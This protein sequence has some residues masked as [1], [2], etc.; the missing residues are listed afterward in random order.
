M[1]KEFILI[2]TPLRFYSHE[3]EDLFFEWLK[4][5]PCV[6]KYQGIGRELHV[7]VSSTKISFNDQI[8]LEGLFKRYRFKNPDQLKQ[9]TIK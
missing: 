5:I 1:D 4:R 9:L 8:N 2:L 7:T 6:K 3:E